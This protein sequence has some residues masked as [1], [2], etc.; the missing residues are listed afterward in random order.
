E[1]EPAPTEE[2]LVAPFLAARAWLDADALPALDAPEA[3]TPIEGATAIACVL[4]LDGR[5]VGSGENSEGD[6][7]MLRRALGRAL[8]QALGDETIRSVRSTAGDRI[9]VRLSLELEAA[10]P[11][12]PLIG[13]TVADAARRV[14]PGAEGLAV[15]R[16]DRAYRAYPSR[17]LASDLAARPERAIAALL[18]DAGLP[19]KDLPEFSREDRV[20]LARFATARLRE[21]RSGDAPTEVT[22]G[23]RTI[24]IAE[25]DAAA[26][27]STTLLLASRLAAQVVPRDPADPAS[28]HALLGTYNPTADDFTPP[29]AGD[30][31]AAFAAIALAEASRSASLPAPTRRA[32]RDACVRLANSPQTASPAPVTLAMRV[33]ALRIAAEGSDPKV[34]EAR[35]AAEASMRSD[36]P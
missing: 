5:V 21:R 19:A 10:G 30:A 11:L 31:D 3:Q 6:A 22:R 28:G 32:A 29:L 33:L 7:L 36:A 1:A 16:G 12:R 9:A 27:R 24:G 23:G 8:A 26:L 4:R 20:S 2:S 18:V 25:V 34:G 15:L 13:R 17:M 35:T 14:Q